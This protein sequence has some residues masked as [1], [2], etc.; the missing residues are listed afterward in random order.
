[1]QIPQI[2]LHQTYAQIGLQTT[3]PVQEI[4]Q[5]AAE[6]SITQEPAVMNIQRVPGKLEIDQDQLWNELNLKDLGTFMADMADESRQVGIDAIGEKAEEGDQLAQIENK[7]DGIVAV[8]EQNRNPGPAE[9]NIAF[10]PSYG[11][12]KI[13]YIPEEMQIDWERGGA[14]IEVIPNRPIINYTPG[15][16]EVYL[17]QMQQLE[18]DFVGTNINNQG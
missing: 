9:F 13:N 4:E 18:I 6:L 14:K 2:R 17:K 8:V 12:V 10:I 3:Q 7:S 11:A 5:P 15:K 16:T 1:M